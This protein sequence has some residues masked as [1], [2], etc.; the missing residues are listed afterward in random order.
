MPYKLLSDH[1]KHCFEM[2]GDC[3][4]GMGWPNQDD[5]RLRFDILT[6]I[7]E[8]YLSDKSK[9]KI[10]D[11]ACGTSA[12]YEYLQNRDIENMIDYT[13]IDI[14]DEFVSTSKKKFPGNRYFCEDILT[15]NTLKLNAEFDF[16]IVN[17]LFTQKLDMLEA[18]MYSFW[19]KTILK[20][21]TMTTF[22][23]A[24]NTMSQL[25]DYK[26]DQAFHLDWLK[27]GTFIRNN[28]SQNLTIRNDYPLYESTF[29]V[30]Q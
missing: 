15:S 29:Y 25:C 5:N 17:G 26:L 23:L 3:A 28:I 21:S 24:F 22:G 13:G 18:E 8:Q 6:N 12:Y 7:F 30:Y 27:A 20:L 1:Y 2:H 9:I 19:E 14:V 11:F 16:I 4:Q 10:L